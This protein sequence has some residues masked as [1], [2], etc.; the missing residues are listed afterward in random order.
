MKFQATVYVSLKSGYSDPEGETTAS[1]LQG[2]GYNVTRVRS[3]KAYEVT[4]EAG[5]EKEA[6]SLVDEMCRR[7]L[8]NPTKDDYRF[9]LRE[10]Q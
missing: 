8:T 6:E 2:L 3:S 7:L 5:S 4:L 9:E 10:A 1:A